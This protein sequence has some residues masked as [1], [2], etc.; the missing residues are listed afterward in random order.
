M[1]AGMAYGSRYMSPPYI[2]IPSSVLSI[3]LWP[4]TSAPYWCNSICNSMCNSRCNSGASGDPSGATW[5]PWSDQLVYLVLAA[6]PWAGVELA[7]G[8]P[9]EVQRLWEAIEAYMVR[10]LQWEL[11]L[12]L[13]RY[14]HLHGVC[15]SYNGS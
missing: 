8:G 11:H 4:S 3:A 5:Q 6:L 9:A 2:G 10:E 15:L 14:Y 7:E 1:A 12:E 13:H